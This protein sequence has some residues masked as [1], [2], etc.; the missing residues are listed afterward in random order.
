MCGLPGN[1]HAETSTQ[2]FAASYQRVLSAVWL[3]TRLDTRAG[4]KV[5]TAAQQRSSVTTLGFSCCG[6][7]G[8]AA[9]NVP[10]RHCSRLHCADI[11]LFCG[12]A[13]D[14]RYVGA[15]DHG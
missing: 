2:Y 13:V 15:V 1:N 5:S 7:A 12:G 10:K 9:R 11:F 4:Q 6:L 8:K 14:S 3:S